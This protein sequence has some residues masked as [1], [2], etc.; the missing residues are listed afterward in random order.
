MGASPITLLPHH[1][2]TPFVR[3]GGDSIA[4]GGPYTA[5]TA[6]AAN[7]RQLASHDAKFVLL[8]NPPLRAWKS[9]GAYCSATRPHDATPTAITMIEHASEI[10]VALSQIGR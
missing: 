3:A 9:A 4:E 10:A 5:M 8:K 1:S 2:I 7:T 6:A